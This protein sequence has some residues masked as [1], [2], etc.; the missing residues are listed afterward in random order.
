MCPKLFALCCVNGVM[1]MNHLILLM[2]AGGVKISGL[3]HFLY[4]FYLY[5]WC[6]GFGLR[7]VFRLVT[8][9]YIH[10]KVQMFSMAADKYQ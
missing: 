4:A 5:C 8:V 9:A 3:Q 10:V 6:T 1:L 2:C 7:T